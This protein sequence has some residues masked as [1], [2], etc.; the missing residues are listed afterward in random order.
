M[1]QKKGKRV[2]GEGLPGGKTVEVN[3]RRE[4]GHSVCQER[5]FAGVVSQG[6]AR[7]ARIFM[8]DSIIRKVNKIVNRG[9]DITVCKNRGCS[10]E[11]RTGHGWWHG[12]CCS[13]ACGNEQCREGGSFGHY[14]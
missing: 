13:C 4:K 10:R 3:D 1:Q 8:G 6:K 2:S 11:G 9:E 14:W 12:R 7:K 5:S